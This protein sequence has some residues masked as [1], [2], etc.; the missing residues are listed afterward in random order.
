MSINSMISQT[1]PDGWQGVLFANRIGGGSDH[2]SFT[3]WFFTFPWTQSA[4]TA[5]SDAPVSGVASCVVT[6]KFTF[7]LSGVFHDDSE[8]TSSP[9]PSTGCLS[10]V[11]E[12]DRGEVI[13]WGRVASVK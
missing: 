6:L 3:G 9:W 10:E 7:P 8:D 11:D 12:Q 2:E 4:L 5:D 1:M 13:A